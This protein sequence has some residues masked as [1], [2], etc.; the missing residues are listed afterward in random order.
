[1][2]IAKACAEAGCPDRC[3]K[4]ASTSKVT[5]PGAGVA[6]M[7]ASPAN[8][9]DI[10]KHMTIQCIGHDKINMMRNVKFLKDAEGIA[11]H[12]ARH[13]AIIGP[14][15]ELVLS[16]L[17][18]GLKELG[19]GKWTEPRGGYF[20]CFN[21]PEGTAKRVVALAKE[22]GV[23]MT[24]AGATWPYG[25]D[26]RDSNIRVAPTMPPIEEL[27]QALDVFVCCVKLA[28]LERLTGAHQQH[29]DEQGFFA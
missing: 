22:A 24:G 7:A 6:A 15:F 4:F 11:A 3:F 29:K 19:I 17:N 16:K 14:K 26:P 8:I 28:Y 25:K 21:A 9:A 18:D 27:D 20:V 13:A 1:M 10:K 2:D 23:T 5:L 12:M